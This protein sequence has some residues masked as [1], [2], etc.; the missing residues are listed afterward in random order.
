MMLARLLRSMTRFRRIQPKVGR[1]HAAVLSRTGGRVRRSRVLAGGQP[2]LALT[3]TGRR[4]RKP[5]STVVAYLKHGD[6][7]ATGALNLGSDH[8]P[9][10]CLNL[11][12]DPR[13]W[14]VV[15]GQRRG[16][17]AREATGAEAE[18]LWRG[19]VERLPAIGNAR[20]LARREVPM[21]VLEPGLESP[22]REG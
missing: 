18:E 2:V 12:S 16:V 21:F 8:H 22:A 4:S 20:R 17:R 6:G 1:L 19:F 11:R 15:D 13:A 7:Y 10:W 9:A 3:T 14:I 5:R